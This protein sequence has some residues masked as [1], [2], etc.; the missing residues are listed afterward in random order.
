MSKEKAGR[1]GLWILCIIWLRAAES[2]CINIRGLYYSGFELSVLRKL[3]SQGSKIRRIEALPSTLVKGVI[4]TGSFIGFIAILQ[5]E[6][7]K[8]ASISP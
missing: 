1:T 6:Y 5:S 7:C 2:I 3:S 4:V 8:C